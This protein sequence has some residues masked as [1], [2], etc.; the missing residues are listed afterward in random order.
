MRY[1]TAKEKGDKGNLKFS[2]IL[3]IDVMP[4][5]KMA[6]SFLVYGLSPLNLCDSVFLLLTPT[7]NSHLA[8]RLDVMM[9][10]E[11]LKLLLSV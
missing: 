6:Q 11:T 9:T 7:M 5:T 8:Y 4:E 2:L 10:S 1:S 3:S